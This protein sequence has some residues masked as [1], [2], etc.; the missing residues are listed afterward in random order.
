MTAGV[1]ET[2]PC[3]WYVHFTASK[4]AL[5][6]PTFVCTGFARVFWSF[7]AVVCQWTSS[8]TTWQPLGAHPFAAQD[9]PFVVAEAWLVVA[10]VNLP[11]RISPRS[12][13]SAARVWAC[14]WRSR[15]RTGR[16]G[17]D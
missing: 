11:T 13:C 14:G 12:P 8:S 4:A 5:S 16:S 3:V 2:S 1:A 6:D 7:D 10:E 17:S 9:A 15:V